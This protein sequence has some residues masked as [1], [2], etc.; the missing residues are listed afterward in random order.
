[1]WR[2]WLRYLYWCVLLLLI[3]SKASCFMS[4]GVVV[5]VVVVVTIQFST[6][7]S[8][9]TEALIKHWTEGYSFAPKLTNIFLLSLFLSLLLPLTLLQSWK[10]VISKNQTFLHILS[11]LK[12]YKICRIF[13]TNFNCW[14]LVN[15]NRYDLFYEFIFKVIFY[16]I[17]VLDLL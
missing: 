17:L 15:L 11:C 7:V 13:H 1:M 14:I 9:V 4:T 5:V 10:Y 8:T 6:L 12:V 3:F 16:Y 2:W